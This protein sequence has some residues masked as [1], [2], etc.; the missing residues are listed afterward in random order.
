MVART[1]E[2]V[3]ATTAKETR[4]P[5]VTKSL[6]CGINEL[7]EFG[8]ILTS[9]ITSWTRTPY[10]LGKHHTSWVGRVLHQLSSSISQKSIV[11]DW[12]WVGHEYLPLISWNTLLRDLGVRI[13][14]IVTKWQNRHTSLQ[15]EI[16]WR[17]LDWGLFSLSTVDEYQNSARPFGCGNANS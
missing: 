12:I 4:Y 14:K 13:G 8:N 2:V 1:R 9:W 5:S 7:S 3:S 6:T 15:S 16:L 11:C 17:H 10:E